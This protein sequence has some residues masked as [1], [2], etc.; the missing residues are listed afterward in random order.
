MFQI[1]KEHL[2][3]API[4]AVLDPLGD[5]VVCTDS[6]LEGLGVVLM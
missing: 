2:T 1:L 4:L 3:S 6:S 5:L